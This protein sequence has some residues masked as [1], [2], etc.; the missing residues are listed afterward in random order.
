MKAARVLFGALAA[1]AA[2]CPYARAAE[3][4]GAGPPSLADSVQMRR[5]QIEKKVAMARSR[6]QHKNFVPARSAIDGASDAVR[7]LQDELPPQRISSRLTAVER[8]IKNRD[9]GGARLALEK[10]LRELDAQARYIDVTKI[11]Q[12]LDDAR[13]F[14]ADRRGTLALQEVQAA[15]RLAHIDDISSP[16]RR[17]LVYLSDARRELLKLPTFFKSKRAAAN[18]RLDA[19]EAELGRAYAEIEKLLAG[20]YATGG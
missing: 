12:H 5:A 4:A 9:W 10:A 16:L 19:A 17:A 18:R 11:W 14:V 1:A 15:K 13:G 20:E 8:Q 3:E 2:L 7:A 6:I